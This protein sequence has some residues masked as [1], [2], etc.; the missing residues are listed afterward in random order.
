MD[1]RPRRKFSPSAMIGAPTAL[2][3]FRIPA[4][5]GKVFERFP[6]AG[7]GVVQARIRIG[8]RV[9]P[10]FL[11]KHRIDLVEV[12]LQAVCDRF[13]DYPIES[14]LR[15]AALLFGMTAANIPMASR[16]PDLPKIART[17]VRRTPKP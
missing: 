4:R 3:R 13:F 12:D 8:R 5:Y 2:L 14:D 11:A 9:P 10:A 6:G 16:K 1:D 15:E 17:W 7:Q